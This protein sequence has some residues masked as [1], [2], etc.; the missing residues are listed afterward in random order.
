MKSE[1]KT[2][3]LLYPLLAPFIRL[4]RAARR[5]WSV[6]SGRRQWPVASGQLGTVNQCFLVFSMARTDTLLTTFF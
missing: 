3:H 4:V 5:Q 2:P 1:S 6:A